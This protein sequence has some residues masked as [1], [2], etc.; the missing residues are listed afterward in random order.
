MIKFFKKMV[1]HALYAKKKFAHEG[2][3]STFKSYS[4]SFLYSQNIEIHENVSIGP[5]CVIDGAGGVIIKN[6]TIIAPDVCIYSRSHNFDEATALPFDNV[7]LTG[8]VYIGE[9]VWIGTKA[10]IL[11]GVFIGDG[12]V[13]GAGAVISKDVPACAVA[14]GNPAKIVK[15]RNKEIFESLRNDPANFVHIKYAHQK[16]FQEKFSK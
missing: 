9:Y 10:I 11:P 1:I 3:N 2:K 14:V 5:K 13:I 6:G 12:A 15:Y 16:I 7:M 4:S 8:K